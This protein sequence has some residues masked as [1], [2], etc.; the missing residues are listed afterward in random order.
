M[1]E[2]TASKRIVNPNP[3][4]RSLLPK[5]LKE[6]LI[7]AFS[8][9]S[10]V[11]LLILGHVLTNYVFPY[12]GPVGD[13]SLVAGLAVL[14]AFLG[15]AVAK[16][17]V[18][19]VIKLAAE[20]KAIAEGHLERQVEVRSPDEVGTLGSAL[21]QITQRVRENMAQ[22]RVYGEQ[23]KHMNLEINRRI[24]TMSHLL[25]VSNLITQQAKVEE[26]TTFIL[27]KLAQTEEAELNCYLE[28]TGEP[29]AFLVRGA[30]GMDSTQVSALFNSKVVAPWLARILEERRVLVID[31]ER[32]Q[33]EEG[34]LCQQLFGMTNA[35]CQPLVS[36]GHGIGILISA[37]R[38]ADFTFTEDCLELLKVFARQ[39]SIAIENDLLSKRAEELKVIDE[40]TG[41]YNAGYVKNRL[42]EEV[43]RAIRYHRPCSLILMNLDH[44][45]RFQDL[46]G[47]LAAEGALKQVADLLREQVTEVDRIG[48]MGADEFAL[49]LPEK[50]KREA[51][52]L[53][54]AIRRRVEGHAFTNGSR[55]IAGV[56]TFS[57]GVS[58]NPLDG[59]SGEELMAK[60]LE[61]MKQAKGQGKNRVI[62]SGLVPVQVKR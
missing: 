61:A 55:A 9:M 4:H 51:I 33:S 6:K 39:M 23:T 35:V 36:I 58:E 30:Q 17:M 53:A 2:R 40:L 13:L 16:G 10:V 41:L 18:N 31:G 42:E 48:R 47:G 56:L 29:S 25:Q 11:P 12:L 28:P 34:K 37:N 57:G 7:V 52:D 15:Y 24:L 60:A 50:N 14:I 20:A 54:E 1:G 21:N 32:A 3:L 5:G 44:F 22:L 8:L 45:K 26:V 49:I 62:A 27:E 19:P 43:R 38:K 46:Y 59:S